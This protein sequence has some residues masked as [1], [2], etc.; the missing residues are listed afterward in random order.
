MSK[1]SPAPRELSKGPGSPYTLGLLALGASIRHAGKELQRSLT[2]PSPGSVLSSVR[3]HTY[4]RAQHTHIH[5]HTH[6]TLTHTH[7]HT[8]IC[9]RVYTHIPIYISYTQL[10]THTCTHMYMHIHTYTHTPSCSQNPCSHPTSS[11]N[12]SHGLGTQYHRPSHDLSPPHL[13]TD[14]P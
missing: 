9:I 5:T 12:L 10:L 14:D 1:V 2:L 8:H 7:V 4:T 13:Y 3:T 6:A 11:L